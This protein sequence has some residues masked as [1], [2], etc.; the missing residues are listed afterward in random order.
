ML[1]RCKLTYLGALYLGNGGEWQEDKSEHCNLLTADICLCPAKNH[2]LL[3]IITYANKKIDI[4]KMAWLLGSSSGH[5]FLL[6]APLV[7]QDITS[8]RVTI[9]S[10]WFQI[11]ETKEF[12][13]TQLEMCMLGLTFG[14]CFGSIFGMNLKSG[15]EEDEHAFSVVK[16][17]SSACS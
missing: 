16:I 4:T 17:F 8:L 2:Q 5:I 10:L 1:F 3:H 6:N 9:R 14:A 12:I 11:D 15:L 7:R 13:N